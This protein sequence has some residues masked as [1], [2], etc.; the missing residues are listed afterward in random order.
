MTDRPRW[1]NEYFTMTPTGT[2][3][4]DDDEIEPGDVVSITGFDFV[5]TAKGMKL[6]GITSDMTAKEA[7]DRLLE[8]FEQAARE[9]DS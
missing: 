3:R 4:R 9:G 1:S 6:F 2:L 7:A 5:L 8:I